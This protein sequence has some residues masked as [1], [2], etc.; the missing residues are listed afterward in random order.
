MYE[1]YHT[2]TKRTAA[3]VTLSP[4]GF[5]TTDAAGPGVRRALQTASE[6]GQMNRTV[7]DGDNP[8][9]GQDAPVA[10]I[11]TS[12]ELNQD[13]SPDYVLNQ[14]DRMVRPAYRI[15]EMAEVQAAR[16][17]AADWSEGDEVD[18]PDGAGVVVE[19]RTE[20]FDGP[21]GAVDWASDDEPA[22]VVGVESGAKVY[23]GDDL[24]DGELDVDGVDDPTG[25][26]AVEAA[27]AGYGPAVA[28]LKDRY[29]DGDLSEA[30]FERL[31]GAALTAQTQGVEAQDDGRQ[32]DYPDSWDESPTPNRIILLKAWAG[33]GGRF[34]TCRR[35]MAGEVASPARFCASMKDRVLLWEGWR[36]GG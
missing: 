5:T 23:R 17:E 22:Y 7:D 33:L 25:D 32:F 34:T 15:R 9:S 4:W 26:L 30:R 31:V 29:R 13:P 35:K 24:S 16:I 10:N 1:I 6:L 14:L 28:E 27:R 8:F 36:Q 18:T 11:P 19:I 21:D 3:T 20:S 12:M 2:D